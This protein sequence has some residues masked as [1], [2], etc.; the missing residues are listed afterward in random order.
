M[1][2]RDRPKGVE[3]KIERVDPNNLPEADLYFDCTGFTCLLDKSEW[4][5]YSDFL[6]NNHAWVT[7]IGY[8]DMEN[9]MVPYTN[10]TALDNGWVWNVPL[11]HRM[12]T[13]YVFSDKFTTPEK[14][15]DEFRNYLAENVESDVGAYSDNMFRLL[16][17]R[18]GRKKEPWNGK[19]VS[20]GLSSGFIEP[21]ESNGLLSVHQML[22]LF[23][24]VMKD[25]TVIT[26]FMRDTFNN[27]SNNAFD[28]FTVSSIGLGSVSD[29]V[30]DDAGTGYAEGD[31]LVFNSGG[32]S[33]TASAVAKVSVISGMLRLEDGTAFNS[34]TDGGQILVESGEDVTIER[35]DVSL[36]TGTAGF[37]STSPYNRIILESSVGIGSSADSLVYESKLNTISTPLTSSNYQDG[38]I[39]EPDT[40]S[41]D[42][43]HKGIRKIN[44]INGGAGYSNLPAVT[45]TSTGGS[46]AKIIANTNNIGSVKDI[47]ISLSTG[48]PNDSP[49]KQIF[50][51]VHAIVKNITGT[52]SVNNTIT[53]GGTG[54]IKN[55][56]SVKQIV[57]IQPTISPNSSIIME[58]GSDI[59]LEDG[60]S[61]IL[62]NS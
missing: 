11:I 20:I 40:T 24:R 60:G 30:I 62:E 8:Q 31:N 34:G 36:E 33:N 43:D 37:D 19:V 57:S 52:I 49:S 41:G 29:V 22:L 50:P 42:S 10:C 13:G 4:V 54:T 7:R 56:D 2:I 55:F 18:C 6:P 28:G 39:L 46:G 25:R 26:Q 45:V 61:T 17:Y 16:K 23:L 14:A 48:L 59:L 5:D 44:F 21:V 38:I 58:T 35:T 53:S 32:Q 51:R 15:R 3:H 12:G 27:R 1:C 47:D 9:Q